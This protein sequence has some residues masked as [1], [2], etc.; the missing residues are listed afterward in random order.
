MI[1]TVQLEK[2]SH[3]FPFIFEAGKYGIEFEEM[4]GNQVELIGDETKIGYVLE[5]FPAKIVHKE[6]FKYF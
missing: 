4:A 5:R 1:I 3:V 2:K 6:N